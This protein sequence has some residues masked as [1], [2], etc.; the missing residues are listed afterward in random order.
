MTPQ[1]KGLNNIQVKKVNFSRALRM[2][3][4]TAWR[5]KLLCNLVIGQRLLLCQDGDEASLFSLAACQIQQP[6]QVPAVSA[7]TFDAVTTWASFLEAQ[8]VCCLYLTKLWP[9]VHINKSHSMLAYVCSFWL[10]VLHMQ[11]LALD[12]WVESYVEV[13]GHRLRSCIYKLK[14][15]TCWI[16][17]G[18][19]CC[20]LSVSFRCRRLTFVS[21]AQE[22]GTSDVPGPG[23]LNHLLQSFLSWDNTDHH[24]KKT[25]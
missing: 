11:K 9:F 22:M 16:R 4:L 18:W 2:R 24:R 7:S 19:G 8:E 1:T 5:K 17:C 12:G 15:R 20:Y 14:V 6:G 23:C 21:D 3:S 13:H 25:T 10:R